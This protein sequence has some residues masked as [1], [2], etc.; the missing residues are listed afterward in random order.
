MIKLI[1][2]K[3]GSGKTKKLVHM[4]N[5]SVKR[6]K[7]H[8]VF[9]DT[10]HSKM[11]Q[12]DY[13]ARFMHLSEYQLA[14]EMEFFGFLCGVIASNYDIEHVY[15][16]GL[17]KLSRDGLESLEP[18]FNRLNQIEMKYNISFVFGISW[19]QQDVPDY[20]KS[21]QIEYLT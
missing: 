21:F 18:F 11:F 16:D 4:A 17:M 19:D 1:V 15:V 3:K 5:E 20:F 2:G 6:A 7:G 8:V 10:D 13:R 12:V 9:I 14:D